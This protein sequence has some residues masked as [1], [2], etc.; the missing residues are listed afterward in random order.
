MHCTSQRVDSSPCKEACVC[1]ERVG[2]ISKHDRTYLAYNEVNGR[3][4]KALGK[5]GAFAVLYAMVRPKCL[6]KRL[7]FVF[8]GYGIKDVGVRSIGSKADMVLRM[9]VLVYALLGS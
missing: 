9:P 4:F 3:D 2:S 8:H 6:W 1:Q 5:F 7:A